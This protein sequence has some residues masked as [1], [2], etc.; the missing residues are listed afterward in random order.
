MKIIL[1]HV[2]KTQDS[3]LSEGIH[4]YSRRISHYTGFETISIS[5]PKA[6]KNAN[7]TENKKREA[8]LISAKLQPS[9]YVVLLDEAG[10]EMQSTEFAKFLSQRMN[11]SVKRL[12]FVIGGPFGFH[13]NVQARANIKLSLSRMTFSHQIVRIIFL[14]QLYRAFTI[15][16]GEKY[17]HE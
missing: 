9:D 16:R 12:M 7:I 14:E 17:H 5:V 6:S 3:Y 15:L 13:E 1:L 2:G 10:Q 8:E 11:A 4:D